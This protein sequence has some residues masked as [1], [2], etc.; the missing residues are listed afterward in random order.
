[1]VYTIVLVCSNAVVWLL[2]LKMERRER[3]SYQL[4][5]FLRWNFRGRCMLP[6]SIFMK[7]LM[8]ELSFEFRL[9]VQMT[10]VWR[11]SGHPKPSTSREQESFLLEKKY[12]FSKFCFLYYNVCKNHEYCVLISC[13]STWYGY[14]YVYL[15]YNIPIIHTYILIIVFPCQRIFL[16]SL[17]ISIQR[18]KFPFNELRIEI[19]WS[20]SNSWVEIDAVEIVGG[21]CTICRNNKLF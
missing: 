10:S 7:P 19:D 15:V 18:V 6:V 4:V 2:R 1:M 14:M 11:Y 17:I 9:K 8:L 20:V 5:L 21:T 13:L 16:C 3:I 12:S